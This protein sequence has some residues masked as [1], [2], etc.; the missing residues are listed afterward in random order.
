[1]RAR[2][3]VKVT[4]MAKSYKILSNTNYML[5]MYPRLRKVYKYITNQTTLCI[6]LSILVS[7]LPDRPVKQ[8]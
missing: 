3:I 2:P 5:H 1:M 4:R 8:S 7:A 6:S